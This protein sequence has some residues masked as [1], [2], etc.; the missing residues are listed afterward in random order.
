MGWDN[1]NDN[2]GGYV[3]FNRVQWWW[4]TTTV[5]IRATVDRARVDTFQCSVQD[6]GYVSGSGRA[7]QNYGSTTVNG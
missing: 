7:R 3:I 2:D 6:S 4:P 5:A 1:D